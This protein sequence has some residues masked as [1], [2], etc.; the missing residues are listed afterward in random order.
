MR[1]LIIKHKSGFHNIARV[2]HR[3]ETSQLLCNYKK[4]AVVEYQNGRLFERDYQLL[5]KCLEAS[6]KFTFVETK[7]SLNC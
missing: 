2:K 5:P 3:N 6:V 1:L 7:L 4:I